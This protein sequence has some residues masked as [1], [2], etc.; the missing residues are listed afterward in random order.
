M[1]NNAGYCVTVS[2][3]RHVLHSLPSLKSLQYGLVLFNING[4]ASVRVLS[5]IPSLAGHVDLSLVSFL[6]ER[7]WKRGRCVALRCQHLPLDC[8]DARFSACLKAPPVLP[9]HRKI[10][11]ITYSCQ[12][13]SSAPARV[14][15]V[16]I[17]PSR[18]APMDKSA[19]T[20]CPVLQTQDL[21]FSYPDIGDWTFQSRWL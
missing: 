20:E 21:D 2:C 12:R 6:N 1:L 13:V 3:L 7:N 10:H 18:G 17:E 16:A 14:F 11:R 9:N 4:W 8:R 15:T 19:S 5:L